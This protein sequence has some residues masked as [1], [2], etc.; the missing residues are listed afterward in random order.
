MELVE[1][2]N[3]DER[4][5]YGVDWVTEYKCKSE[6]YISF[7]DAIKELEK[8]GHKL[9]GELSYKYDG[10]TKDLIIKARMY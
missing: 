5:S 1:I 9:Y 2:R 7:N 6:D 10:N 3:Y 4:R 8:L